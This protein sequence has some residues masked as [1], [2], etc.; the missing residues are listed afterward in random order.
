MG[1]NRGPIW[2]SV[3]MIGTRNKRKKPCKEKEIPALDDSFFERYFVE[4]EYAKVSGNTIT[5]KG[6]VFR[7]R[8]R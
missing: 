1:T 6:M 3:I 2:W 8:R 7:K 5:W 4:G